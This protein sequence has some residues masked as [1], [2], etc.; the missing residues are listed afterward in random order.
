MG[1]GGVA[2]PVLGGGDAL[3]DRPGGPA[4]EAKLGD[5]LGGRIRGGVK[6]VRVVVIEVHV[7]N[8]GIPRI[9]PPAWHM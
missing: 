9:T 3:V 4:L 2:V 8:I 5:K 7:P 6:A 1:H